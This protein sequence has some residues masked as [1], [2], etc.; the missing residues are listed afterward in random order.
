MKR[1]FSAVLTLA[2]VLALVG[3]G[4]AAP[5]S[6]AA[7]SQSQAVSSQASS[8]QEAAPGQAYSARIGGLK[9]PTTLGMLKLAQ[10][11]ADDATQND[12]QVQMY[13]AA[14][15]IVPL[16]TKGEL[17][18][19]AIPANLAATLYNKTQGKVQ[20]AAINTLGVLYVVTTGHEIDSVED[21][22][23]MTVY[24]TGKGTTPE[25]VLR[26]I[27]EKNGMDPDKDLSLEY[28]SEATEVLAH[29]QASS[30]PA[31]AVLPQPYV[32]AAQMQVEGLKV[33]LS[34]TEEWEKVS[35]DSALVTGVLAVRSEFAAEHPEAVG[36]FLQEY[37]ASV[38]YVNSHVEEAAQWAESM[39]VVAKAAIAQK[40]IPACNIVYQAGQEMKNGLSG[41]LQVLFDQ[42][43][44]AVGGALPEDNFY[45]GV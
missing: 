19:A 5:A 23:G 13:G 44:K 4:Q 28:L 40:A 36:A 12:W 26:Y 3:C 8:Q 45:Y 10:D 18:M 21:L 22:R 25:F 39:G 34:L 11:V 30:G 20:V 41:Y 7:A 16:L 15:E 42:D 17:D 24:S 32:T 31:V 1:I 9:G 14:D 29:I 27:L 33:A 43:P 6:S 38:D 37:Q 35:P 2:M